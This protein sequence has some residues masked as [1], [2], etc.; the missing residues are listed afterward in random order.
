MNMEERYSVSSLKKTMNKK[1][2]MLSQIKE[3]EEQTCRKLEI[4]DGRPYCKD[5]L[6]CKS[7]ILPDNLIVGDNLI[8]T[9]GSKKFPKNLEARQVLDIS[10]TKIEE[11][12]DNLTLEYFFA[13]NSSLK[14]LPK[15]LIVYNVLNI[16]GSSVTSIPPNC[17]ARTIFCDFEFEDE[18]YEKTIFGYY[19][20]KKDLVYIS[21]PSGRKFLHRHTVLYEAF[22]MKKNLYYARNGIADWGTF[23]VTDGGKFWGYGDSL[24]EAEQDYLY[25]KVKAFL[26]K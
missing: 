25:Q 3:F 21:H 12:C 13:N 9:K 17:L 4:K 1:D 26:R 24:K 15:N 2:L 20:L 11:V 14:Q 18:R 16:K 6:K 10:N 8:C 7:D 23:I 19:V 5:W 22:D